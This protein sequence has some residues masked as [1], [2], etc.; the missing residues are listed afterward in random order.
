M[1]PDILHTGKKVRL[2]ILCQPRL[3]PLSTSPLSSV[4]LAFVLCQPGLVLCQTRLCHLSTLPL[5]S[6]NFAFVLCQPRLCPLS[7]SP[8]S[9][10]NLAFV[11]VFK[12]DILFDFF[13]FQNNSK[14][15]EID[16]SENE[17]GKRGM[18]H[19]AEALTENV[20]VTRA[21][22]LFHMTMRIDE[23]FFIMLVITYKLYK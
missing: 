5:S 1:Y 2:H 11:T 8:L 7:T 3:C 23:R 17:I 19:I 22:S 16:L 10:V 13:L 15:T 14:I 9:S 18:Y 6:V 12:P 21:V 4:N 20:F